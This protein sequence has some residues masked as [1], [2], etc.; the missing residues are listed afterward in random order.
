MI[1]LGP[2]YFMQCIASRTGGH[3]LSRMQVILSKLLNL[4]ILPQQQ[5]SKNH[6]SYQT[7]NWPAKAAKH[8]DISETTSFG[9]SNEFRFILLRA[10]RSTKNF[11][12]ISGLT[13]E[14]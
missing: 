9:V 6:I 12:G 13:T 8:A 11:K 4:T 1:N 7:Q 3:S 14:P 10:E 5:E 2:F